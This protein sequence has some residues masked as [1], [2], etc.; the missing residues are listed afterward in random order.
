MPEARPRCVG[1]ILAGGRASR[2]GG[3]AKGLERVGDVRII[4][5]IAG[6]LGE[7]ADA[8]LLVTSVPDSAQ[9][10]PGARVVPDL[11]P[12]VGSLGG[13]HAALAHADGA[14]V[15]VVAWDMPFVSAPLLA[16]LRTRGEAGDVDAVLPRSESGAGGEPLCAWYAGR[17]LAVAEAL[18]R[19]GERRAGALAA[20][21]RTARLDPAPFGDPARLFANV[22]TPDELARAGALADPAG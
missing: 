16:A 6:A 12:G 1:A 20:S 11:H 5:R 8:T 14:D 17:C 3:A 9:W 10:L 13:L 15:L 19:A 18:V 2:F 7:M 21:V 4:D 22:N